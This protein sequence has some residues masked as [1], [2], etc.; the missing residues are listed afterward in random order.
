MRI[1]GLLQLTDSPAMQAAW[2]TAGKAALVEDHSLPTRLAAVSTLLVAPW[3]QQK[4]LSALVDSR[5]PTELQLAAVKALG[6]SDQEEVAESLLANWTGLVPKVQE[7]IVDA[8]FARQ[9]R[10]PQLLDAVE[11]DVVSTRQPGRDRCE[12][13]T[14]H[15]HPAIRQRARQ[16]LAGRT[17]DE[18]AAVVRKYASALTLPRDPQRGE[19]VYTKDVCPLSQAGEQR[20]RDRTRSAGG[21]HAT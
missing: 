17:S 18:R 4:P 6:N 13:L 9:D 14:E 3:S 7:S 20:G 19:A 8:F 12:Q 15:S 21:P 16:L 11:H 5:Q 10:L 2:E 1:A